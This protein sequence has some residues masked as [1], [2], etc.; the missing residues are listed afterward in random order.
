MSALPPKADMCSAL[1]HVCF[2][3]KADISR[4][5]RARYHSSGGTVVSEAMIASR[6]L[7]VILEY[8]A[9]TMGGLSTRPSR[10]IP[11]V[12]A[13]LISESVHAPIPAVGCDV[14]FGAV[15]FSQLPKKIKTETRTA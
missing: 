9:I 3:P 15:D 7:S 6:S 4:N 12:I 10:A 2:V 14:M 5:F 8:Q 1:A 13:R 11:L